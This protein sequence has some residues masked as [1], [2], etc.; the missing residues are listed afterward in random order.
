M[1]S[2]WV[3]AP[4]ALVLLVM[5]GWFIYALFHAGPA[6]QSGILAIV[7]VVTAGIIANISAKKREIEARHFNEKREG[8]TAFVDVIIDTLMAEKRGRK[9]P[10][11]RQLLEKII[12]YKKMLWIWGDADV[13]KMWNKFEIMGINNTD[14]NAP[15]MLWDE[16][17]RVMRKDLGKDDS[18]LKK[19]ELVSL[20]LTPEDKDKVKQGSI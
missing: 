16:L 8:Y 17:L 13:I 11:E 5:V 3:R 14:S 15:L 4:G 1:R 6:V 19:G 7:G 18:Q 2:K 12:Q 10:S 20:I 9:P